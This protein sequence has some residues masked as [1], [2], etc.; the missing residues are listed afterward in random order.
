MTT[1]RLP[2]IG[3]GLHEAE[4]VAWHVGAGDHVV[5]DQPLVSVETDKAVVEI[6][7]PLSGHIAALH[8]EPGD[9]IEIGEALVE[10]AD[11]VAD[12]AGAIV[13]SLPPDEPAGHAAPSTTGRTSPPGASHPRGRATPAVRALASALGVDLAGVSATGP[14]GT[15]TRADVHTAAAASSHADGQDGTDDSTI[16]PL[17]GVRRAMDA[18]M[19]RAHA[20]V[21]PATVT[22]EA[23]IADWPD[24]TDPTARLLRAVAAACVAEP[25]LN[26]SY[27]GRER[28]RR[29]NPSVDIGVAVDTAEGL[30]VPVLR[31]VANRQPDDVRNALDAMR[32]DIL[33]RTVPPEH[34]R[35]ATITLSNFGTIGGRHAAL[36][37]VPPQVAIIGAGRARHAVVAHDGEIA[38]RRLLPLSLTFDHRVVMGGEATRFLNTL[39]HNLEAAT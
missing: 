17:R 36:V 37:V 22:D 19:T 4:I 39:K 34:L 14:D 31:D 38:I 33:A 13:G 32:A 28:G 23:D 8:G 26:A 3:E 7:S 10:F 1:F 29:I 21:V 9:V 12:D 18:N 15:V 27:L 11:G 6:P 24:A 20:S 25:A 16:E 30:F 5:T 2:D 35:G